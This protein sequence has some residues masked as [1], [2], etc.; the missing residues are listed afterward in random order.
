MC[1]APFIP[2]GRGGPNKVPRSTKRD[3]S[4][5]CTKHNHTRLRR[6]IA[7][8]NTPHRVIY[9]QLLAHPLTFPSNNIFTMVAAA[10]STASKAPAK[11]L[12]SDKATKKAAKTSGAVAEGEK[13]KRRKVR[14]ETYASYI[15]KGTSTISS[16]CTFSSVLQC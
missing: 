6:Y 9:R 5:M 1:T 11:T 14:K 15:Y 16:I 8:Y 2:T 3:A 10:A 13:K 12:A 4:V 7:Q